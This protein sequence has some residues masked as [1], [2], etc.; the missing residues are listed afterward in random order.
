M[1]KNPLSHQESCLLKAGFTLALLTASLSSHAIDFGPNGEFS[2][3]GFGE[4]TTTLQSNY[5]LNCQVGTPNTANRQ[6]QSSD[7]IIPGRSYGDA[8]LTNWQVQPYLGYKHDLG[9]GY[10][11]DALLSQRWRQGTVNGQTDAAEVRYGGTVDIPGYWYQKNIALSHEDYGS[12][13]I[14]AMTTRSWDVSDYP[15]ASKLGLSDEW[16]STGAGYGMLANAIRV[17]SP[18]LDV[19]GGDLHQEVTYDEGNTN[20]QRL[21]PIFFEFYGQYHR[22]D[23]VVDAMLQDAKNGGSGSWGHAP[24]S[25]VSISQTDDYTPVAVGAAGTAALLPGNQQ[26]IA[27]LMARYE[28]TSQLEVVGGVRYNAWGGQSFAYS[29]AY[30]QS[31][32]FNV[33]YN[34]LNYPGFSATSIDVLLGARYRMSQWGLNNLILYA[35][36]VNLGRA[37]TNNPEERGQSNSA[38]INTFGANYELGHGLMLE[39]TLGLVHYG[40][41]GLAP[42][43][44]PGNAAGTNVDSRITQDGHWLTLG[45]V[46]SF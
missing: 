6:V 11:F 37:S 29:T 40:Q 42:L 3:T 31:Y 32:A 43:S 15:Y 9:G 21:R 38:L 23:L 5:C 1:T 14:G 7:P 24:F 33:N 45:M 12:I 13:R 22:G 4:V 36:M 25:S 27:L 2:L 17:G 41:L 26:D 39:G 8:T 35:G 30:G 44:M 16:A 18:L 20:F 34:D 10:Q 19:A 28:A 46:Y